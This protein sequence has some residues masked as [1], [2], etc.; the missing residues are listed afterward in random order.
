M[1][2]IILNNISQPYINHTSLPNSV[3][4]NIKEDIL[5][6]DEDRIKYEDYFSQL[7]PINGLITGINAK[8]FFLKSGFSNLILASIWDLSDIDKDGMLD[9]NEFC[10]AMHLIN[11]KLS[12]LDLPTPPLNVSY[13]F[14]MI[15]QKY[16]N[17]IPNS[18]NNSYNNVIANNTNNLLTVGCD[19][20]IPI[21][22]RLRY[23]QVFITL[24][25]ENTRYITGVQAKDILLQSQLPQSILA[26][27]WNLS[28]IDGDGKL[29][30]EEFMLANFLAEEYKSGRMVKLPDKLSSDM[31]PPSYKLNNNTQS[32]N[33][34]I[35]QPFTFEDKRRENFDMGAAILEQKRS[36]LQ[37]AEAEERQER[38]RKEAHEVE[39]QRLIK[40]EQEKKQQQEMELVLE[41][42]K[43]SERRNDMEKIK[44][45]QSKEASRL[46]LEKQMKQDLLDKRLKELTSTTKREKETLCLLKTKEK[47]LDCDIQNMEE[48]ICNMKQTLK[49]TQNTASKL[50]ENQNGIIDKTRL[51]ENNVNSLKS[52]LEQLDGHL[53]NLHRN[54][55][56]ARDV[57]SSFGYGSK[58]NLLEII[59]S[60]TGIN[61]TGIDKMSPEDAAK[62][63]ALER[64]IQTLKDK[65]SVM[66]R[67]ISDL[68][69]GSADQTKPD[70]FFGDSF[71]QKNHRPEKT[72]PLPTMMHLSKTVKNTLES[73]VQSPI[74]SP[75][76]LKTIVSPIKYETGY[77]IIQNQHAEM[78]EHDNISLERERQLTLTQSPKHSFNLSPIP[79]DGHHGDNALFNSEQNT[80]TKLYPYKALYPFEARSEDEL[81]FKT[82]DIIMVAEAEKSEE[83]WLGGK[84]GTK[85]G[86]FPASYA[87][88]MSPT[89]IHGKDIPEDKM[90]HAENVYQDPTD[91][92]K[93]SA[94][95]FNMAAPT[96]AVAIFSLDSNTEGDLSFLRGDVID[97][98]KELD[99]NWW[100]ARLGDKSGYVPKSY[101]KIIDG[102]E[103]LQSTS[104]FSNGF[105]PGAERPVSTPLDNSS[106]SDKE[107]VQDTSIWP[108]WKSE[109]GTENDNYSPYQI[110]QNDPFKSTTI[111]NETLK[112]SSGDFGFESAFVGSEFDGTADNKSN[113]ITNK[114]NLIVDKYVAM[115]PFISQEPGDLQFGVGD[116]IEVETKKLFNSSTDSE[117]KDWWTGTCQSTLKSGI[118]PKNYVR[119]LE[120]NLLSQ[121]STP[122]SASSFRK[123]SATGSTSSSQMTENGRKY[124]TTAIAIAPF[125]ASGPEQLSLTPGMM[126]AVRRKTPAGWWEGEIIP[127][128]QQAPPGV[129]VKKQIGWFPGSHVKPVK[130]NASDTQKQSTR[131]S[132]STIGY[133]DPPTDSPNNNIDSKRINI[134]SS[135]TKS[136]SI[137]E[138]PVTYVVKAL[139]D[140]TSTHE[141]DLT[142]SRGDIIHVTSKND[143]DWWT[144]RAI[145]TNQI[146]LF[147]SNHVTAVSVDTVSNH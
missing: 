89:G 61:E 123:I 24:D 94:A 13:A 96:K 65:L 11:M 9:K 93:S 47:D 64:S 136:N 19:W 79:S 74:K 54:K 39:A 43:E 1:S 103:K 140:Y 28:D 67:K 71:D 126:V 128:K 133:N 139:Y 76:G 73:C 90:K 143:S 77:N 72:L 98:E 87:T 91:L 145:S 127:P 68:N 83:G 16:D 113:T 125:K 99:S 51:V 132:I 110:A 147:P 6:S 3:R 106:Y 104:I 116:I 95:N 34:Q 33:T 124:V 30:L 82:G 53:N 56:K 100:I 80:L 86:W 101:V 26:Q 84:I 44:L 49:E 57:L 52:Q 97:I 102:H 59:T 20:A 109:T 121:H 18:Q 42:Q 31:L 40:M 58:D 69:F 8:Q 134:A 32:T 105:I 14:N 55:T 141:G 66:N 114:S 142:F 112:K 29:N 115:Y 17:I 48:K 25:K 41:R 131:A 107:I 146:G 27:I 120:E 63:L 130:P 92:R 122:I 144:G 7:T 15:P 45:L 129:K 21:Q 38:Q 85:I 5:I 88:K 60:N 62:K 81:T 10:I 12:G 37:R 35:K 4:R 135:P 111:N 50:K 75:V 108:S 137:L 118:F 23:N 78:N 70:P 138:K 22:S 46:E 2:N 117:S 119:K 36:A